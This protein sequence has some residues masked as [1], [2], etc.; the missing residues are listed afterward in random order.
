MIEWAAEGLTIW[1]TLHMINP[2]LV[3][4]VRLRRCK[5]AKDRGKDKGMVRKPKKDKKKSV[6][7][8]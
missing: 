2:A 4:N 6:I 1:G 8:K 7:P 5:M 3:S